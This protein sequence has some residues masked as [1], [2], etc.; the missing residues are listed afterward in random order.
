LTLREL[1]ELID[2][3]E[4][5]GGVVGL[6]AGHRAF[7]E[8]ADPEENAAFVTVISDVYPQ[9]GE[10]YQREAEAWLAEQR[11]EE[12]AEEL[13]GEWERFADELLRRRRPPRGPAA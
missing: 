6:V 3:V 12:I 10:Y 7:N 8:D 4:W 11:R 5:G 1:I 9:L 2:T 13:D